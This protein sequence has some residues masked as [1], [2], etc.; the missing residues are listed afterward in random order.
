LKDSHDK[1]DIN[2]ARNE[3]IFEGV[4]AAFLD[5][6]LQFCQ[7]PTLQYLWT[8]YLPKKEDGP[9]AFKITTKIEQLLV[10]TPILR[11]MTKGPLRKICELRIVPWSF[12]TPDRKPLIEDCQKDIDLDEKYCMQNIRSLRSL[13][14]K[15]LT[16]EDILERVRQDL[17]STKSKFKSPETTSDWHER[18]A[19]FFLEKFKFT[20]MAQLWSLDLV[21][22]HDG[23]YAAPL[24]NVI[25]CPHKDGIQIPDDLG[26]HIVH[27]RAIEHGSSRTSLFRRLGVYSVDVD[28][29]RDCILERYRSGVYR[30][31]KPTLTVEQSVSHL[32]YLYLTQ[33]PY[34]NPDSDSEEDNNGD[35]EGPRSPTYEAIRL[36]DH[37]SALAPR[38]AELYFP[39]ED[40]FGIQ[41]LASGKFEVSIM[42]EAYFTTEPRRNS[43]TDITWK[44]WLHENFGVLYCP[45][46]SSNSSPNELSD[47]VRHIATYQPGS[48]LGFIRNHWAQFSTQLNPDLTTMIADVK[49]PCKDD[50]LEPLHCTYLPSLESCAQQYLRGERF[51]F[52]KLPSSLTANNWGFLTRFE[53]GMTANLDFYLKVLACICDAAVQ[54]GTD[55]PRGTKEPERVLRLYEAI[56]TEFARSQEPDH[57]RDKI[58]LVVYL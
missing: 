30:P 33:E 17:A 9:L 52:L 57:D 12:R 56:Q 6:V 51:P 31:G 4:A 22:L 44:D 25:Y 15:F 8:Q 34:T 23:T 50:K 27:S 47:T 35:N 26:L 13:G 53:V 37:M 39:T 41:K 40:E 7:H 36:F 46:L 2:N 38:S 54:S 14:L 43:S 49:V 32:K 48:F 29:V 19:A 55:K 5:A 24:Y 11:P 16:N 21:P 42:N 58:K 1:I 20:D 28:T 45:N 3:A 18:I 10:Q